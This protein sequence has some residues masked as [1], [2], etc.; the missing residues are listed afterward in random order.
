MFL[1]ESPSQATAWLAVDGTKPRHS[2]H[3][4]AKEGRER[5]TFHRTRIA[6]L[7]PQ[8][9]LE[10]LLHRNREADLLSP[11]GVD[12]G[13]CHRTR[14]PPL[15]IE[16]QQAVRIR[17]P[18]DLLHDQICPDKQQRRASLQ[19]SSVPVGGKRSPDSAIDLYAARLFLSDTVVNP[20]HYSSWSDGHSTR[21]WKEERLWGWGVGLHQKVNT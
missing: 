18:I 8:L 5:W 11:S 1:R 6:R 17:S 9:G 21:G 16:I 12:T 4:R 13:R 7:Y 20:S 15:V 2:E 19:G 10:P 3:C 14:P